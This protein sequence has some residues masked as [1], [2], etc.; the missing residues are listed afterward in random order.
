MEFSSCDTWH[1]TCFWLPGGTIKTSAETKPKSFSWT[2]WVSFICLRTTN[3]RLYGFQPCCGSA[4]V[5]DSWVDL[6]RLSCL[7]TISVRRHRRGNLGRQQVSANSCHQVTWLRVA[8]GLPGFALSQDQVLPE[9][10]VVYRNRTVF[11]H[12]VLSETMQSG[13]G[14]DLSLGSQS[15]GKEGWEERNIMGGMGTSVLTSTEQVDFSSE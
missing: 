9:G 11:T 15:S 5:V 8:S 1:T 6:Q 2:R 12:S 10:A 3:V 7:R 14:T 4:A 13:R